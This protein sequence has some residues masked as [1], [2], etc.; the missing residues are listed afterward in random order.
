MIELSEI[1]LDND[2]FFNVLNFVRDVVEVCWWMW[3]IYFL[4]YLDFSIL[5]D[6]KFSLELYKVYIKLG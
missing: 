1:I 5:V 3:C 6:G 2:K 4:V